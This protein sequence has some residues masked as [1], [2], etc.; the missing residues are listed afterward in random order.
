MSIRSGYG[1]NQRKF[2]FADPASIFR[3]GETDRF[4]RT[5]KPPRPLAINR[6]SS[7]TSTDFLVVQNMFQVRAKSLNR[8]F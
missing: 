6:I 4:D 8:W 2:N 7:V 5:V 3:G 1:Q